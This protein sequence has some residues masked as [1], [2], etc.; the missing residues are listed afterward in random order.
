MQ[1]QKSPSRLQYA[2]AVTGV[3]KFL[4]AIHAQLHIGPGE[5]GG[6]I[7]LIGRLV[8]GKGVGQAFKV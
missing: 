3:Q 2:L 5:V 1:N 8:G 4:D 7:V 6:H